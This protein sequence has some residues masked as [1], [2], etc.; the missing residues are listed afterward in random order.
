MTHFGRISLF[1]QIAR[2]FRHQEQSFWFNHGQNIYFVKGEKI[3]VNYSVANPIILGPSTFRP[4][5]LTLLD[6]DT[7]HFLV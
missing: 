7:D 4:S 2:V 3:L 6:F 1:W 5:T